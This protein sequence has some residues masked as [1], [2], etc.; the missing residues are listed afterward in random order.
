MP[1]FDDYDD[2]D[3]PSAE[4][5]DTKEKVVDQ[6]SAAQTISE[7]EAEIAALKKLELSFGCGF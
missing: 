4:L 3:M 2:D 1:D 5:E 6:A 7:L